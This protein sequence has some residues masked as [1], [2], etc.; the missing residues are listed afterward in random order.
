MQDAGL[1]AADGA[2]DA[3]ALADQVLSAV[4]STSVVLGVIGNDSIV[5]PAFTTVDTTRL[6]DGFVNHSF[7]VRVRRQP[8]QHRRICG[9][10]HAQDGMEVVVVRHES[11]GISSCETAACVDK[12][13]HT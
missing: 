7:R 4:V 11:D 5:M 3:A 10:A 9:L 6:T 12:Y 1:A 13:L 8:W 2:G